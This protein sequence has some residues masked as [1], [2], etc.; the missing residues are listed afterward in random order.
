MQ[1]DRRTHELAICLRRVTKELP[2]KEKKFMFQREREGRSM[3]TRYLGVK[4][5]DMM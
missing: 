4:S 1:F 5:R 2:R 3:R